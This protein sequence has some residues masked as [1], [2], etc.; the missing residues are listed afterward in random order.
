MKNRFLNATLAATSL[1]LGAGYAQIASA[2]NSSGSLG[3]TAG[4]TDLYIASCFN[5]NDGTGDSVRLAIQVADLGPVAAPKVSVQVLKGVA[6][7][8]STDSKDGDSKYS[9]FV[10]NNGGNGSYY[11]IVSKTGT[12]VENYDLD[13]HC[14][15]ASGAHTGTSIQMLQNQ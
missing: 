10:Y 7:A 3:Q 14:Q 11:V 4:S 1:L 15:A 12:G 9:P 6:A 13:F 2:H 5:N 8:T